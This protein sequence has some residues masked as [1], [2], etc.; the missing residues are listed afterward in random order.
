M[1]YNLLKIIHI[2]SA[3]LMIGT[4]LGSA[5]YLYVTYKTSSFVTVKEVLKIV[6]I[7]DLI[8]TTPSVITQLITGLLLSDKLHLTETSWYIMVLSVSLVVL[9]LWLIAVYIQYQLKKTIENKTTLPKYFNKLMSIWFY[10]G[11]PSFV[12]SVYLYYLMI[13]KPF[14]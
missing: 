13:Y 6:I 8:F 9:V 12:L 10:L 5:F 4:G 1:S 11:I 3:T 14:I 2:L 7:A